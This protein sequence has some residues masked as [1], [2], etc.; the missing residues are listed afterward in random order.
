MISSV[1]EDLDNLTLIQ[2]TFDA[3]DTREIR[4]SMH[5]FDACFRC[6]LSMRAFDARFR[7]RGL[8]V[9]R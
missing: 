8:I 6:M 3:D 7:R 5:A 4:L 9:I 2:R 1:D